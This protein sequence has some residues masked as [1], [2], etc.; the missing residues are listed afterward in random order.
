MYICVYI[1]TNTYSYPHVF[2]HDINTR[3]QVQ[4][5]WSVCVF[6]YIDYLFLGD[7]VDR[8]QHSLETIILLLA[9]KVSG[10][11]GGKGKERKKVEWA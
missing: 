3:A 7:Y 11:G 6:R 8:G 5:M 10:G 4:C 2:T 1:C 9:L